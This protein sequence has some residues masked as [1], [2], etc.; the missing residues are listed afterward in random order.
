MAR[1]KQR[2]GSRAIYTESDSLSWQ[3]ACA[4]Y[5][6]DQQ[7][8]LYIKRHVANFDVYQRRAQCTGWVDTPGQSVCNWDGIDCNDQGQVYNVGLWQNGSA[9]SGGLQ[10]EQAAWPG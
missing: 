1:A 6:A 10:P 5:S 4:G 9:L 3:P 8:L 7:G 2:L